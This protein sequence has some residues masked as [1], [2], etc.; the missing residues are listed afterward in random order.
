MKNILILF[1][2]LIPNVYLSEAK[3]I[4]FW[5]IGS[6]WVTETSVNFP[7]GH[8]LTKYNSSYSI[9]SKGVWN[10]K[11][12]FVVQKKT[13]NSYPINYFIDFNNHSNIGYD[14]IFNSLSSFYINNNPKISLNNTQIQ[15]QFVLFDNNTNYNLEGTYTS[16]SNVETFT[17]YTYYNSSAL[18]PSS[19]ISSEELDFASNT[20]L[21]TVS[22]E[23]KNVSAGSFKCWKVESRLLNS[24]SITFGRYLDGQGYVDL[25]NESY[26]Y[27]NNNSVKMVSSSSNVIIKSSPIIPITNKSYP[28]PVINLSSFNKNYNLTVSGSVYVN[29][30]TISYSNLS[31]ILN[32]N[33]ISKQLGLVIASESSFLSS[34]L[35]S[36]NYKQQTQ[37]LDLTL[38]ISFAILAV[39][40]ITLV[41]LIVEWTKFRKIRPIKGNNQ[42][43]AFFKYLTKKFS[44]SARKTKINKLSDETLAKIESIINENKE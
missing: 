41:F 1:I 9:Q 12:V 38:P 32:T 30:P 20:Y 36:I 8:F 22:S 17:N 42:K 29:N 11:E 25:F 39:M 31:E 43:S 5:S 35:I 27:F 18:I 28:F 24:T 16:Y 23:L 4:N 6:S 44:N 37:T 13:N 2:L 19:I 21:N 10:N 15:K 34:E 26:T 33:W 3:D 14:S 7:M 40:T